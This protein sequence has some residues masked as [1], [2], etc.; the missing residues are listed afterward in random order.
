MTKANKQK[1]Q[2][3][4]KE[5]IELRISEQMQSGF[6]RNAESWTVKRVID[7]I[8]NGEIHDAPYQRGKIWDKPKQKALIETI[9]RYGGEKIPTIT[10]RKLEDDC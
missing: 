3:E 1:S 9:L 2:T 7:A 6:K 8:S 5:E 4:T 10:L